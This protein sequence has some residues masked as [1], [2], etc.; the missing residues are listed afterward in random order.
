MELQLL[1]SLVGNLSEIHLHVYMSST[2]TGIQ[3]LLI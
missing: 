1:L 2:K 3:K